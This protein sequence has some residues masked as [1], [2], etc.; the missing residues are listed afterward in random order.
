MVQS[1][2][3][4]LP[5]VP[6]AVCWVSVVD[7]NRCGRRSPAAE[8]SHAVAQPVK[9]VAGDAQQ[10]FNAQSGDSLPANNRPRRLPLS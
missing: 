10:A 8:E 7:E 3:A 5:G 9:Y 6:D 1:A 4:L 2:I